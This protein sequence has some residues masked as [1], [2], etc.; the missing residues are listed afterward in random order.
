MTRRMKAEHDS[1]NEAGF[2][3]LSHPLDTLLFCTLFALHLNCE[4]L[5]SVGH[6]GWELMVDYLSSTMLAGQCSNDLNILPALN[7]SFAIRPQTKCTKSPKTRL[8]PTHGPQLNIAAFFL[9]DTL[10]SYQ[11]FTTQNTATTT[12]LSP[13]Q[14]EQQQQHGISWSLEGYPPPEGIRS[15]GPSLFHFRHG[16]GPET[17][18]HALRFSYL[19]WS[20]RILYR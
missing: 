1:I 19:L 16:H 4:F 20:R 10:I 12:C 2:L 17:L 7:I 13:S 8:T 15:T 3:S 5:A 18:T 11:L 6:V 14:I 9:F